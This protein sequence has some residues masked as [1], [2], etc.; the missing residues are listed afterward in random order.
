MFSKK[1][2]ETEMDKTEAKMSKPMYLVL[3]ILGNSNIAMHEYCMNMQNQSMEIRQ[4]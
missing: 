3:S 1:L 4:N 2:V